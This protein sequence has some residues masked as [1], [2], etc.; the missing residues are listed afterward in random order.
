M[1]LLWPVSGLRFPEKKNTIALAC[2][3]AL[4]NWIWILLTLIYLDMLSMSERVTETHVE[5][6]TQ[7][8][9]S[10]VKSWKYLN[11][12]AHA[13]NSKN[14]FPYSQ[15]WLK[16]KL[17]ISKVYILF[18]AGIFLSSLVPPPPPGV[19]GYEH[20]LWFTWV[21]SWR[22]ES[23]NHFEFNSEIFSLSLQLIYQLFS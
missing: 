15:Y 12:F 3:L 9:R 20:W 7:F 16:L 13:Q 8:L 4:T 17:V 22:L 21:N 6:N 14:I 19:G 18:K 5:S 23:F 11:L 2:D 1:L 10:R